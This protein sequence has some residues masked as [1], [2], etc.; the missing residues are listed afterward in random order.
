[1]NFQVKPTGLWY[2]GHRPLP[3]W[4]IIRD[5]WEPLGPREDTP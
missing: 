1:M 3:L 4:Q 2:G 5:E